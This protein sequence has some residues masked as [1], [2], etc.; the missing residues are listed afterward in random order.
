MIPGMSLP[1]QFQNDLMKKLA[2]FLFLAF[3][4]IVIPVKA[5][6]TPLAGLSQGVH[7][8]METL[9]S[10][11]S[12]G[13]EGSIVGHGAVPVLFSSSRVETLEE[14]EITGEVRIYTIDGLILRTIGDNSEIE[15]LP[16][17]LYIVR[18]G[19][20]VKKYFKSR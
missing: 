10:G 5:G 20:K 6:F 1:H 11:Y 15:S 12:V 3:S 8:S 14:D 13:A 2:V 4:C 17:G 7:Y 18:E 9:V 16:A 19:R